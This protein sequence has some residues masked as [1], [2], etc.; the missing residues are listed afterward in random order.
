MTLA[1]RIGMLQGKGC[2]SFL[3]WLLRI[4]GIGSGRVVVL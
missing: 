1:M 4:G 3:G 2:Q